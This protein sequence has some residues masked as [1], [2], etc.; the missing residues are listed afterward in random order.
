VDIILGGPRRRW[1]ADDKRAIVAETFEPGATV[2]GVARRHGMS[3]SQLFAWRRELRSRGQ[4]APDAA[5]F[6]PVALALPPADLPPS[7]PAAT[8]PAI[9]IELAR[10]TRIRI[11]GAVEVKLAA[12]VLAALARR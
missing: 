11:I 2:S 6:A 12:A 7:K 4:A 3:A 5:A 9:E 10:G 8:A 1:S